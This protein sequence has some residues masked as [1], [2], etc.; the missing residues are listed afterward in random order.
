MASSQE[1]IDVPPSEVWPFL[2]AL[3]AERVLNPGC[4]KSVLING[5]GQ[6][7]LRRIYFGDVAFDEMILEC[8]PTIYKFK[9]E[10]IEP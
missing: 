8:D 5:Q 7:A 4:T 3:G 1:V 2:S 6:G 10:V 9:Y